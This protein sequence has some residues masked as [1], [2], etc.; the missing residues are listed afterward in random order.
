LDVNLEP[1][2][3]FS[4]VV[5]GLNLILGETPRTRASSF[6]V[7]IIPSPRILHRAMDANILLE[8][9]IPRGS[10]CKA[11]QAAAQPAVAARISRREQV[12]VPEVPHNTANCVDNIPFAAGVD[13]RA[14]PSAGVTG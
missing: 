2:Y 11:L 9:T 14:E 1:R 5:Q 3:E 12:L 13:A 4:W 6:S 10:W 7:Q 8:A